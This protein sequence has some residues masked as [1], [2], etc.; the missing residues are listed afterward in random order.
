MRKCCGYYC[1]MIAMV[2]IFFY[3]VMI[4]MEIRRNQFVLYKL[5]YPE[6]DHA[7]DTFFKNTT[8]TVRDAMD[9][10][11]DEKVTSL[12]I[13]IGLNVACIIGCLVQ[14]K[15]GEKEEENRLRKLEKEQAQADDFGEEVKQN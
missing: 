5:Q 1:A 14:V 3:G 11:A 7:N 12:A 8:K 2:A 10:E 4:V 6:G 15:V 9:H 13:A